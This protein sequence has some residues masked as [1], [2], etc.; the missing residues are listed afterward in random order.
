MV[1]K[2]LLWLVLIG[3]LVILYYSVGVFL[4]CSVSL[5]YEVN[6]ARIIYGSDESIDAREQEIWYVIN[7]AR[8][9]GVFCVITF[10]TS[11]YLLLTSKRER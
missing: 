4:N 3:S 5:K 10:A 8:T 6:H 11:I 1:R 7:Y 9:I 2:V